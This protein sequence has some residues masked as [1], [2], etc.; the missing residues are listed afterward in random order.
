M[1]EQLMR[2]ID[3]APCSRLS[4]VVS[5]L[6]SQPASAC[7]AS[8]QHARLPRELLT[9]RAPVRKRDTCTPPSGAV[10]RG[11]TA[12][13]CTYRARCAR[14][15]ARGTAKRRRQH[16][17]PHACAVLAAKAARMSSSGSCARASVLLLL[18][19][20]LAHAAGGAGEAAFGAG[21]NG[22]PHGRLPGARDERQGAWA[23][24][25]RAQQSSE[26][27][28]RANNA[29]D[30]WVWECERCTLCQLSLKPPATEPPAHAEPTHSRC[31]D[32]RGCSHRL[33]MLNLTVR[34]A[35]PAPPSFVAAS[36]R[37]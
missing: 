32:C 33:E 7:V 34:T 23:R 20:C 3:S 14:T 37:S 11:A 35:K 12:F 1:G 18:L 13:A 6:S 26:S 2:G 29:A 9:P 4:A 30:P 17:C 5:A 28:S 8:S 24:S 16:R 10:R 27:P 25:L 21:A 15:A 22:A 36:S 31:A 19:S